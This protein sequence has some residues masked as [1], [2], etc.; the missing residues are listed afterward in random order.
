MLLHFVEDDEYAFYFPDAS[1]FD[2]HW[3]EAQTDPDEN[4]H[5]KA[6]LRS[7]FDWVEVAEAFGESPEAK[8]WGLIEDS[9]A[10]SR[11]L[12]AA[13]AVV[14]WEEQS[15]REAYDNARAAISLLDQEYENALGRGW[16]SVA[17]FCLQKMVELENQVNFAGSIEVER[18]VEL[19]EAITDT[20][21][22]H[23]GNLSE[24]LQL[25]VDNE[26]ILDP[27][28]EAEKRAFVL[29]IRQANRLR[30]KNQLFQ[31]RSLLSTT[32]ELAEIL[33]LPTDD[34]EERYV[35]TYRLNADLQSDQS[36]SLEAQE[37]VRALEDQTVLDRLS[38]D[39]KEEWKS[40]LRS[41]VQSAAH[42]LKREGAVI[43]SP[44]QRY[45]H[46]ASVEK[47]VR[48]FE[49][50][51]YVYN[52]DAALFWLLTHD[53]LI[54]SYAEDE[55]SFGIHDI[56][57]QTIYSLQ[58]HLIEFDPEEADLSAR[59]SIEARI[60]ISTVVSVISSLISTG[61]LTEAEIYAFLN[62][63]PDLDSK[64]VWYLTRFIS[65]VF[66]GNDVEAIH[67]GATRVEPVL[68]NLLRKEGEDVD[69]LM[70]DGTGTRTLGS[71]VPSLGQYVSEDFQEYIRY[72]Y[73]EPVGQ[74][75]SGNI[76]N[77]VAHGLLLPRES[78]RLY[79][80]L[81][82]TD[83]LRIITRMNITAHHARFGIP[84]TI[85]IPTSDLSP[86]FPFVVRSYSGSEL[87]K[88]DRFLDY[89]DGQSRTV[90]EISECFDIPYSLALVRIRLSEATGEILF[91]EGSGVIEKD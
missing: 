52:A 3:R 63:V 68:Y 11:A 78:N 84:D 49:H 59:Y 81:I 7:I 35:D 88:Q 24:S 26:P 42:E 40:R 50:I 66:D 48:Q 60:A 4:Y 37:L 47:F 51:K 79:S 1:D 67:L 32:I 27:Q 17:L 72:T 15:G 83:L 19:I 28:G 39:D 65:N 82:L 57:T 16:Y 71:L 10:E 70:D 46:Q 53:E 21:D 18:T 9:T 69:A 36:A 14:E 85:L 86:F 76:R 56:L 34:L 80:L 75:F 54:P 29:C 20:S 73:N 74:M 64:N 91:D 58:G 13:G 87:P 2:R 33:N 5:I 77:R 30:V 90:E 55:E 41:A 44:H 6:T 61:S 62:K 89:L 38:D 31:E 12:V 43:D 23:L 45:L 8:I 25:L 22:V